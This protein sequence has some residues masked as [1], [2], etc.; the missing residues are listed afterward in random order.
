MLDLSL[1][2]CGPNNA[3]QEDAELQSFG[4]AARSITSVRARHIEALH[5]KRLNL[6]IA[7]RECLDLE[8]ADPAGC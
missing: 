1:I 3:Q 4:A 6:L 2:L 7:C 5:F 8:S